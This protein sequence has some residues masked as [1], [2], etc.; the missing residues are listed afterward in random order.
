MNWQPAQNHYSITDYLK[1]ELDSDSKHEYIDGQVYA[2][3][4]ASKNHQH[5][6]LNIS[7]IFKIHLKNTPCDTFASDIKA[8]S[9]DGE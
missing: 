6:T 9:L 4:G 2:M 8:S 3:A 5:I 7:S 1:N